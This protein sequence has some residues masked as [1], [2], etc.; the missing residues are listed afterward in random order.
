MTTLSKKWRLRNVNNI[1]IKHIFFMTDI[2][3]SQTKEL[4]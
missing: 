4:I 1:I 3:M 2:N